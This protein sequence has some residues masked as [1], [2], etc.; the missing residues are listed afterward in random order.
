MDNDNN[1]GNN[2]EQNWW[3]Y[4]VYE[5]FYENSNITKFNLGRKLFNKRAITYFEI[6]DRTV[7]AVVFDGKKGYFE[8]EIEFKPIAGILR[9]KLIELI[10]DRMDNIL[11]IINGKFSKE[12]YE[13]LKENGIEIFPGW[14][15]FSYKC[16]CKKSKKCDHVATVLHRIT[17]EV[18]FNPILIFALRGISIENIY[19]II[20]N[21]DDFELSEIE[22]PEE[23]TNSYYEVG[24]SPHDEGTI[25]LARYYGNDIPFTDADDIKDSY[26]KY[27][28]IY[29]GKIRDEFYDI[30]EDIT[31]YLKQN[32]KKF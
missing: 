12:F 2:H 11:D 3:H 23:L 13:L 7:E 25:K 26:L 21:D 5:K 9:Q 15:N 31:K 28:Q 8:I 29:H 20:L 4:A 27:S 24:S 1:N 22:L 30:Y 32:I 6:E 18:T 14:A 10:K 19:Q 16:N 17:N